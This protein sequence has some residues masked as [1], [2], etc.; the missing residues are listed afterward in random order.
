MDCSLPGSSDFPGKSTRVDCH[1]LHQGIFPNQGSNLGLQQCMWML[2]LLNEQGSPK[3]TLKG[4][5]SR[6]SE[7]EEWLSELENK[8]LEITSEEKNKVK[9]MKRT[10]DSL[11]DLWNNIKHTNI[12]VTG[13]PKEE[14]KKGYE[15]IFEEIIVESFPNIE[16][17]I[18]NQV[19]EAQRGPYRINPR[20]NMPRHILIKLTNTKHKER[21]LKAAREKQ[22]VTYKGNPICLT[23]DLSAETLQARG[24]GRI[25]LKINK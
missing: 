24:N 10:E 4:I 14:K 1:F 12:W 16:K 5:I 9:R 6:K 15:K 25:Y 19:Q 20:R 11:R 18:V 21:T 13:L 3:N 23:A 7:A 8:M 17:E 2:Y 22:Q